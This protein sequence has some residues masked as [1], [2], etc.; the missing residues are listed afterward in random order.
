MR[1]YHLSAG[2]LAALLI[3]LVPTISRGDPVGDADIVPAGPDMFV[4]QPGTFFDIPLVGNP[5]TFVTAN[6]MGVP[7][8]QG[9]DT[10]VQRVNLPGSPGAINVPDVIGATDT[11]HTLM[12][13]LDLKS[14]APVTIGGVAYTVLV[15]LTPGVASTG[16]LVFT[17]TVNGEG[18]AP[19]FLEGTFMSTLDVN[20]TL[21]F[22][23]NGRMV[24]C[25]ALVA[26]PM[27][28]GSLMLTGNGSWTDDRGPNWI[29]GDVDEMHPGGGVHMARMVPEP[30]SLLLMG[31]GLLG[32]VLRKKLF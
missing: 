17:Q 18:V 15:G 7:N 21:T 19:T 27:C 32:G 31:L 5:N 30:T 9:A 22:E 8:A 1:K 2:T 24:P 10:I 11:V 3:C 26:L 4:T 16:T 28:D 20:F 6:F 13:L 12:T 23:Q 29:I 25:P 14:T